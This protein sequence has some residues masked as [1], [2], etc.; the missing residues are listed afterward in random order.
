MAEEEERLRNEEME[1]FKEFQKRLEVENERKEEEKKRLIQEEKDRIEK[2][3]K[4]I[5]A[6]TVDEITG[7]VFDK[8]YSKEN[9]NNKIT[10]LENELKKMKDLN[11]ELINKNKKL[12]KEIIDLKNENLEYKNIINDQKKYNR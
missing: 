5:K 2:L 11:K 10:L 3:I 6:P 12:E 4:L 1:K 9:L 7:G 8:Q